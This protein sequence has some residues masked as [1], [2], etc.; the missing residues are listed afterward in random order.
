MNPFPARWHDGGRLDLP[1]VGLCDLAQGQGCNLI[2]ET[3]DDAVVEC[4]P[5]KVGDKKLAAPRLGLLASKGKFGHPRKVLYRFTPKGGYVALAKAYRAY[6]QA[7]GLIVTLE[8]KAKANP[9][10]RRL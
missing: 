1:F 7:H 9:N 5:V 2:L 3:P 10:V 8:E 6:A 4:K